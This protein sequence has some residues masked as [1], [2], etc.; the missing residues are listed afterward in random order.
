MTVSDDCTFTP[1]SE[2]RA[3]LKAAA[4]AGR[5][6]SSSFDALYR[7]GL[8]IVLWMVFANIA[9]HYHE[10]EGALDA[11][12]REA[13]EAELASRR[14]PGLRLDP[15]SFREFAR[16]RGINHADLYQKRSVRLQKIATRLERSLR[17]D[18]KGGCQ[19]MLDLYGET[20]SAPH[21]LT[22]T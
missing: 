1:S 18:P 11:T 9:S 14:C 17:D 16:E 7:I 3:E 15:V 5:T 22:R 12:L 20:G 8:P 6:R 13:V 19:R 21:L 4:H 2:E 10:K